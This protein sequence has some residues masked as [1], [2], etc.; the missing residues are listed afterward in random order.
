MAQALPVPAGA[1]GAPARGADGEGVEATGGAGG[2]QV[3]IIF[4]P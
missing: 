3:W 4:A 1:A 2:G